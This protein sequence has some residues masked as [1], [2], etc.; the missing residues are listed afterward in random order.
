[1]RRGSARVRFGGWMAG[2]GKVPR[3]LDVSEARRLYLEERSSHR[4]ARRLGVCSDRVCAVIRDLIPMVRAST[5]RDQ[6]GF[7]VA[8]NRERAMRRRF[9]VVRWRCDC[10]CLAH[11]VECHRGHRAPWAA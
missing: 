7:M 10:G 9:G 8:A 3:P 5:R 6:V 4:V 11:G 1:M 2:K